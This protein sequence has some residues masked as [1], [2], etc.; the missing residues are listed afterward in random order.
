MVSF[1]LQQQAHLTQVSKQLYSP[2]SNTFSHLI[3]VLFFH[4]NYFGVTLFLNCNTTLKEILWLH[5]QGAYVY[6]IKGLNTNV[7]LS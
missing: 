1:S 3:V 2:K 5:W 6:D 4:L 7:V